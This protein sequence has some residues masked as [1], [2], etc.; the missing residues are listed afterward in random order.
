MSAFLWIV[1]I[2][3]LAAGG[4]GTHSVACAL[5]YSVALIALLILN[6]RRLK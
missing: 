2:V 4:Q 6:K 1:V 5:A 3:S